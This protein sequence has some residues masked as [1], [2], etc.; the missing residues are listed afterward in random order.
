[1]KPLFKFIIGVLVIVLAVFA[2][3]TYQSLNGPKITAEIPIE[4]ADKFVEKDV[5]DQIVNDPPFIT[6][7]PRMTKEASLKSAEDV[8]KYLPT[9]TTQTPAPAPEIQPIQSYQVENKTPPA[10]TQEVKIIQLFRIGHSGIY[11]VPD[12]T[13][14][15]DITMDGQPTTYVIT[16]NGNVDCFYSRQWS[17]V[18][19]T[20]K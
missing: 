2:V 17:I 14:I 8:R 10:V 5:A 13:E 20:V 18:M 7:A 9:V 11:A 15:V 6:A 3:S 12:G 19:A 16:E 1:L 4:S